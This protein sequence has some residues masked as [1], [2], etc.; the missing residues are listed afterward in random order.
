MKTMW[1]LDGQIEA[2]F[3]INASNRLVPRLLGTSLLGSTHMPILRAFLVS[4][5]ML[6]SF[7]ATQAEASLIT[8]GSF[9]SGID[10]GSFQMLN[11]GDS[12]SLTGWTIGSGNIDYIGSYWK[13]SDQNRSLD[14]NGLVPGSIFQTFNGLVAGQS[15]IVTFD[16]AGNPAGGPQPKYITASTNETTFNAS[17]DSSSHSPGSMGWTSESFTFV[18]SGTSDTLTFAS[19]T[20]LVSGNGDFP[21]AFGP[22]LDNVSVTPVPEPS[23]WAMMI[24]GFMGIG[25]M[26]YRRKAPKPAFRLA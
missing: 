4:A 18:A 16:L 1:S 14:L 25:F 13:A 7:C 8:N 5:A 9:E 24:V 20:I 17:F 2:S 23:T 15:Y 3:S 6:L 12:T 19:A 26:A 11:T 10:P 22:A 21:T